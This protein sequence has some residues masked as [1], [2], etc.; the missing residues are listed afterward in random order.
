MA[1]QGSRITDRSM[2]W[3]GV[4]HSYLFVMCEPLGNDTW[5]VV[6]ACDIDLR[7]RV[8]NAYNRGFCV[9]V[10][11]NLDDCSQ[12]S[13]LTYFSNDLLPVAVILPRERWTQFDCLMEAC[14]HALPL[15]PDRQYNPCEDVMWDRVTLPSAVDEC[16]ICGDPVE[17][18]RS[19]F[20]RNRN[21]H[22]KKENQR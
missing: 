19:Y 22:Q 14:D 6:P 2:R 10:T 17:S 15:R 3:L 12:K 9:Y 4:D 8:Y 20:L 5:F 13:D 7:L 21:E 18:P 11:A 1:T 16:E